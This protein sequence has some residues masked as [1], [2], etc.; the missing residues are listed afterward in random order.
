M[1]EPR[2]ILSPLEAE[3]RV[4]SRVLSRFNGV[5]NNLSNK[6]D[7][8]DTLL[9]DFTKEIKTIHE[10]NASLSNTVISIVNNLNTTLSKINST[11]AALTKASR[12]ENPALIVAHKELV[13]TAGTAVQLPSVIIPYD[14]EVSIKAPSTNT[15][16]IYIGNSKLEA[17]DHTMGY[18]LTAS[19]AI[20]YKIKN[21]NQLW[22][23]ATVAGEG[24]V[25]TV[26]QNE[27]EV[28]K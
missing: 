2:S 28:I 14:K 17:E 19:E 13:T 24:V 25:W 3:D 21:L 16:T 11:L 1:A 20:E 23:D 15:G 7:N 8:V 26:E 27:F 5:F 4:V 10:E 18:P 6:L 22:I 12:L 9:T